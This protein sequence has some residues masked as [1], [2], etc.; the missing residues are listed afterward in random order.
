MS[1]IDSISGL[2]DLTIESKT[3]KE[4]ADNELGQDAFLKLLLAQLE[5]QDPLSPTENTEFVAQ[6]AEFTNVENLDQ[7]NS[8]FESLSASLLSNQ[9]LEATSLVGTPVS[10]TT[11]TSILGADGLVSGAIEIPSSTSDLNLKIY[12]EAGSLVESIDLGGKVAGNTLFR[13]DGYN[14]EVDGD[15]IDWQSSHEEGLPTGTYTFE[16]TA[17]ID[18]E[19]TQ[20]DTALS[21]NVNS[22]AVGNDGNLI[23][24][25][26]GVGPV[27]MGDIKQFN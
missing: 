15:L 26:A 12:D 13:W 4:P 18:G 7:L 9:A 14:M 10:V 19:P 24:N 20:L 6:L 2:S 5:N 8:N 1:S 27:S 21:A 11:D 17:T 16:A 22:V 23:L 25:L 3:A